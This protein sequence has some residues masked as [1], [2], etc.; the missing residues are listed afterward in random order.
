MP[1]LA[2]YKDNPKATAANL[3]SFWDVQSCSLTPS[4]TPA[5]TAD[6]ALTDLYPDNQPTGTLLARITNNGPD[7][8]ASSSVLLWC[9]AVRH[10]TSICDKA[11][12]GPLT[13]SGIF[14]L[15]PGQTDNVNMLMGLDTANYWYEA[16]CVVESLQ[17]SYGDPN[18]VNDTYT[19]A[20]PP[21]NGDLEVEDILLDMNNQVVAGFEMRIPTWLFIS[22]RMSSS[23]RS[24]VG[25]G[26]NS[27][28]VVHWVSMAL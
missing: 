4:L 14:S 13:V 19:E 5:V 18:P 1:R 16:T 20:I 8:L 25:G 23:S 12:L 17:S 9:E 26:I 27:C 6:M 7:A 3:S 21:A 10:S 2:D 15:N 24:P 22:N 11:T 28:Q